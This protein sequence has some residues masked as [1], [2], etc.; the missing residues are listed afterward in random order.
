MQ[1]VATNLRWRVADL[2]A[3]PDDGKRREIIDGELYVST[4]PHY[5]HQHVCNR[6]QFELTAW[7]DT[8]DAGIVTPA[9]G[10]IF[11]EDDAVAPD[12]IWISHRRRIGA[13]GEDGKYHDAPDLVVEVLSYGQKNEQ[14]DQDV[15]LKLYPR[16]GVLEYWI[17]DWRKRKV[18]VYR[19]ENAALKQSETLFDQD[20]LTSPILPG[21]RCAV[22]TLFKD[23]PT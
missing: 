19:R 2:E 15:K 7:S 3:F 22:A 10:I 9:P 21:F 18:E 4:Q 12:V 6:A 16:R 23:V 17:L 1:A 5:H 20:T 13:E 11:S 14:R 8:H